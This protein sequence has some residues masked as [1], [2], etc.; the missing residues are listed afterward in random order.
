MS[1]A[2]FS[3]HHVNHDVIIGGLLLALGILQI[4]FTHKLQLK[5]AAAENAKCL[6]AK[7]LVRILQISGYT[8]TACGL[9]FVILA[10]TT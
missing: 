6:V 9:F 5:Q 3:I 10:F 4:F 2:K 7:P 8:I 1:I